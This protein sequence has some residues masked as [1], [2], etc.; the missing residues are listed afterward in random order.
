MPAHR[1][2]NYQDPSTPGPE[3]WRR[4]PVEISHAIDSVGRD[5]RFAPLLV[6]DKV[7]M[8]GMSAGGHTALSLPGGRW[9]PARLK[10][11][12]EAHIAEDFYS[13]VGL[14]ARLT[15]G[16]LDGLKETIALTV[17]RWKFD[18]ATRYAY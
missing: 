18:D 8:Y 3:S 12:C 10:E 9:S 2:D 15:G 11:H 1:G 16:Y 14:A 7:G 17:I 5:P 4:R 6:L 13:C